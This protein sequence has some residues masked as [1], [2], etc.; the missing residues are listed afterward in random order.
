M[1]SDNERHTE[2]APRTCVIRNGAIVHVAGERIQAA[3]QTATNEAVRSALA[4]LGT[5][6]F[7]DFD[8]VI[9]DCFE[10]VTVTLASDGRT[11][12]AEAE[13]VIGTAH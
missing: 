7:D 4:Q 8:V 12:R 9:D 3:V 6:G 11:A 13:I 5:R 10:W 2:A 1:H